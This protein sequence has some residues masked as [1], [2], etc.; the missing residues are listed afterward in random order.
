VLLAVGTVF[1]TSCA[2]AQQVQ[3]DF[4]SALILVSDFLGSGFTVRGVDG[5]NNDILEEDQLGMLSAVLAGRTDAECIL[6]SVVTEIQAGF[7]ANKAAVQAELTVT[8]GSQGTVDLIDQ[9]GDTNAALGAAMQ[10]L[11]AGIM[12]I[13]DDTTIAYINALADQVIVKVLT[14]TPEEDSIGSVQNQINF[15]AAAFATFGDAG[16]EPNYLGAEGDLDTD[17][18]TNLVEY[19]E[20]SQK[21]REEWLIACCLNP[22][23][24][25]VTLSGGGNRVT[26]ITMVFAATAA[27]GSGNYTYA[28]HKGVPGNS[29]LLEV[30]NTYTI[31]F[32]RT[33]DAGN[34]FC[35]IDDG[36]DTLFTPIRPMTVT[37]VPLFIATPLQNVT[38][39]VGDNYTFTLGV[40]GGTPGPYVFEWKKNNVV[41][42]GET[43]RTL[44]LTNL[45]SDDAGQYS[46]TVTSNGGADLKSSGPVTLT[47]Q[48]V[49]PILQISVQ[50]QGGEVTA[51]SNFTL[52]VT[53]TGG[54]GNYTYQWRKGGVEIDG[55]ENRTLPFNPIALSNS[56]IYDCVITDASPTVA[57][58]TSGTANVQVV[59]Q[60]IVINQ[61][62]Q[63]AVV[64]L[65]DP[66]S[67][68]IAVSGGSGVYIYEWQRDEE[69]LFGVPNSPNLDFAAVSSADEGTYRCVVTDAIEDLEPKISNE[70]TLEVIE[71]E[72][73]SITEEPVGGERYVGDSIQFSVA[74]TGG[75]GTFNYQWRRNGE[76]IPGALATTLTLDPLTLDDAGEITCFVTDAFL[77]GFNATTMVAALDVYE[78]LAITGSPTS[79]IL[80][81]GDLLVL[82]GS[83]SGGKPPLTYEW[84]FNGDAT[85]DTG[86]TLN[87]GGADTAEAGDYVLVV[88]D[89]L[90]DQ[91]TSEIASV[92]VNLIPIPE[93]RATFDINMFA[94]EVVPATNSPNFCIGTGELRPAGDT[95]ED[96]AIVSISVSHSVGSVV[97]G[98]TALALTLN[99]GAL[100]INGEVLVNL[101]TVEFLIQVEFPVD[102][103]QAS[104]ILAG[105][106]YLLFTSSTFPSGDIRGQILPEVQMLV[107]HAADVNE[108]SAISLSELLRVIQLYNLDLFHCDENGEDG[109]AP[110]AG[111]T[112][113]PPH[114]AD[115]NPQNWTISLSELLRVIQF[116]NSIGRSFH[117][118]ESGEDGFCPGPAPVEP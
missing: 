20:P 104:K 48:A 64:A 47:V 108:D 9:L 52:S 53:V 13:A 80:T 70:V 28:W 4:D 73:V 102:Q 10:N 65:G 85:G 59:A 71:P 111:D 15:T 24:R 68:N 79:Q 43:A 100:G 32:L 78:H 49:L 93:Y 50:P 83:A 40:Q 58:I 88:N 98:E 41:I 69:P 72:P 91:A 94:E 14:G 1:W 57:P 35:I 97:Q 95:Q 76:P 55:A 82:T 106:T 105:N 107:G 18:L 22:P 81:T 101:N 5:D 6:P 39:A 23:L 30:S 90:T 26:G 17:L 11:L 84:R 66:H 62:P 92:T 12:T 67:F 27:G 34:Y 3:V 113:C 21:T 37:F 60:P 86:T 74:A 33:S 103:V 42:D 44:S 54:S 63:S 8:V 7:A 51:G 116:Y 112:T 77:A 45:D 2:A 118:C 110:G 115:Y 117:P 99:E 16:D 114:S 96:G 109:Y 31:D 29:T 19:T 36:V 56:G 38:R 25:I 61:Q 46:V 87:L 89:A 75:S